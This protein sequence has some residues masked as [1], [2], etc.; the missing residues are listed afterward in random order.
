MPEL[1]GTAGMSGDLVGTAVGSTGKGRDMVNDVVVLAVAA[2]A[3][4]DDILAEPC[5]GAAGARWRR[6]SVGGPT[7]DEARGRG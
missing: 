5:A 3:E 2:E 6:G 1:S 4:D 7:S